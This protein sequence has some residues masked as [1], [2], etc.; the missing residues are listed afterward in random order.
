LFALWVLLP[1]W[2][3]VMSSFSE[4]SEMVARPPHWIPQNPTLDNYRKIFTSVTNANNV[5]FETATNGRILGALGMSAFVG[6]SVAGLSLVIG[7][8]AAYGY[9]RFQFRGSRVGYLF[10]LV[11]RVIPAIAII[12]P[13]FIAFRVTGLI[14]TPFALI[15]SYLLFTLPLAIWLLKSYFDALSPEIEEAAMVD[16]ASRLRI[17]WVLVAPLALPGLIATGLLVFLESWSEF[18]YANVLTSQL[19][20]PPLLASYNTLQT[21]GWNTMAAATMLSLIP[22]LLIAIVFQRFVVS[23]LSHGALK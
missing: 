7:G 19:T 20:V 2:F 9:S 13:F 4:P 22:P 5:A 11:S 16:G 1:L 8:L 18:Y 23:G 17:V 10:L 21:F 6:M 14:N 12:T 15:I 3:T